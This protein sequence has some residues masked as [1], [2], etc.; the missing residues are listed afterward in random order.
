VVAIPRGGTDC[1]P[2]GRNT[3]ALKN[4]SKQIARR[5]RLASLF[6]NTESLLRLVTAVL[7]EVSEDWETGRIYATLREE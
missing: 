6:P 3:N 1:D 4:L 7:T 2:P 5:T